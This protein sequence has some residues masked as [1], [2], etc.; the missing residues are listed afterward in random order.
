MTWFEK[1]DVTLQQVSHTYNKS[2]EEAHKCTVDRKQ[3]LRLN[4]IN[5][6]GKNDKSINLD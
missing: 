4:T 3:N 1:V 5:S 6:D 2:L